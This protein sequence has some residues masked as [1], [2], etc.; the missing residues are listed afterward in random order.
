LRLRSQYRH[1]L[2]RFAV[3]LARMQD[4]EWNL[5]N[6]ERSRCCFGG[7]RHYGKRRAQKSNNKAFERLLMKF[8]TNLLFPPP[9]VVFCSDPIG[10]SLIGDLT[11]EFEIRSASQDR[12]RRSRGIAVKVAATIL[13]CVRR[14]LAWLNAGETLAP[15]VGGRSVAAEM[16][17]SDDSSPI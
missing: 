1:D 3:D 14:K 5:K 2:R 6:M 12:A 15:V 9:V 8:A 17:P 11:G 4:G 13:T 16:M 7:G 10:E